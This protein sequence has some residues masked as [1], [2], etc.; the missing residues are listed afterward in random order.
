MTSPSATPGVV[1]IDPHAALAPDPD[2][3]GAL[4]SMQYEGDDKRLVAGTW[5]ADAGVAE[6]DA[7]P[8]DEICVVLEGS[9]T[10]ETS[11]AG[12]QEFLP[13]DVFAIRRGTAL[14]WSQTD[15]TRKVYVV[16]NAD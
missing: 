1:R 2:Q 15:S 7:Y 3:P 11:S 6:L 10:V 12:R 14:T 13:G 8:V 9:I 5:G 4:V 16:L